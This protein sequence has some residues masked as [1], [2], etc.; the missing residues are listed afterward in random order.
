LFDR[1]TF[2]K[3]TGRNNYFRKGNK[4]DKLETLGNC[5]RKAEKKGKNNAY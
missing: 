5:Y 2:S 1:A 3:Q 4:L